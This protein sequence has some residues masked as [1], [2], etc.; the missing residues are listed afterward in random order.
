VLENVD[1]LPSSLPVAL[2]IQHSTKMVIDSYLKQ[3]NTVRSL[4]KPTRHGK[5]K[6]DY[7]TKNKQKYL[8]AKQKYRAKLKA[9]KPKKPLSEFQLLKQHQLLKL[10]V[11]HKSFVKVAPKLKHPTTKN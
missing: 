5:H 4:K 1:Y 7:Y 11:N 8:I 6:G 9:N 2:N 3:S 10:L